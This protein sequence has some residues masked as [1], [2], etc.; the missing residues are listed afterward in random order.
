MQVTLAS[1]PLCEL[2]RF[3]KNLIG[4]ASLPAAV[5]SVF[6]ADIVTV[7][8]CLVGSGLFAFLTLAQDRIIC[9]LKRTVGLAGF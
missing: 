2:S 5:A 6:S 9:A 1:L 8:L 7:A 3:P 4:L